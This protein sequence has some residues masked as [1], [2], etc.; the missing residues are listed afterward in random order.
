MIRR[1]Q[2]AADRVS[3]ARPATP[4]RV[5]RASDRKS[6]CRGESLDAVP[7]SRRW[8]RGEESEQPKEALPCR[9]H[10][11]HCWKIPRGCASWIASATRSPSCPPLST[12]PPR[13]GS[14]SSLTST[15]AP[16]G[17]RAHTPPTPPLPARA[18]AARTAGPRS[19]AAW[20]SWR[21]GLDLG[22]AR[23]RVR[24]A[25]A[26]GAL[27]RLAQALARGELSYAKGRPLHPR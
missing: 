13:A 25:H 2:R 4:D 17:A 26:L 20:L 9:P 21:V 5:H 18:R 24:V 15:P 3:G 22:A 19:G 14:P 16:G 11:S 12:P 10:R 1:Q 8:Y 6:F 27:P 23:E 7:P